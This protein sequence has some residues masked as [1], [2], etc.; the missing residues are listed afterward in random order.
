ML[1]CFELNVCIYIADGPKQSRRSS[2]ASS[3]IERLIRG[4]RCPCFS[5]PF[6][7]TPED[8]A[9]PALIWARRGR[10][11]LGLLLMLI[12]RAAGMVL[13]SLSKFFIDDVL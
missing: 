8:P 3:W 2:W 4:R 11:S 1:S 13:P 9:G 5:A 10:L 7:T 12:S 6:P